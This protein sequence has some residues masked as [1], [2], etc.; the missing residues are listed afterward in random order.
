MKRRTEPRWLLEEAVVAFHQM[1]LAQHGG[2]AGIRD[3]G[4]LS[5]ALARPRH[6]VEYSEQAPPLPRLAAAYSFGIVQDHPF[7]DGN[8]RVGLMAGAVFLEI[9]GMSLVAPEGETVTV[10]EDVAAGKIGEEELS[11]WFEANT[12]KRK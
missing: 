9:N 10:F 12:R 1:V 2:A 3:R 5:S 4:L 6:L 8:K 11:R 7:V